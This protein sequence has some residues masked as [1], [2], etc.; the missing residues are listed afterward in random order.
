MDNTKD[1]NP[2]SPHP[3]PAEKAV[4]QSKLDR[5]AL[6]KKEL[7]ENC[8][9][10]G[11]TL[12]TVTQVQES[13]Q[14]NLETLKASCKATETNLEQQKSECRSLK[15]EINYTF[16]R[17]RDKLNPYSCSSVHEQL[18]WL[19]QQTERLF[20]W[21]QDRETNYVTKKVCDVT[22]N[23][24]H[25]NCSREKQ[26]LEKRLREMEKQVK[27]GQEEKKKVLGEKEQLGKELEEKSK[28]AAQATYFRDQFNIC[29]NTKVDTFFDPTGSR[30]LGGSGRMVPFP[31]TSSYSS[32][33]D[34][35]RNQGIFG[36]MGKINTEEIQ[37]SV[38]KIIEQYTLANLKNS[39]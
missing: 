18:D 21:Q 10:E 9:K 5:T 17:I 8:R 28:A 31:S 35:L 27:V 1:P 2:V 16:Q 6:T 20:L 39:R 29:M 26:E 13:C 3:P 32:Y 37:R 33:V 12:T 34:A 4:L 30:V 15:S 38:Q 25:L 11:S 36:N 22:L 19:T 7:E 14:Q 23:Q 24:C